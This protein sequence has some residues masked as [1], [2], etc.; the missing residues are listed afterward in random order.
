MK[1]YK[2]IQIKHLAKFSKQSH[3][4]I[5]YKVSMNDSQIIVF[6]MCSECRKLKILNI[7]IIVIH[8]QQGLVSRFEKL[9]YLTDERT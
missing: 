6:V 8:S 3:I 9:I 7:V 5:Q 4:T 1:K 2:K